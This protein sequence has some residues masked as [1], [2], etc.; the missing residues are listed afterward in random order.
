[1][2]IIYP[3]R[4]RYPQ[5]AANH[6]QATAMVCALGRLL[7]VHIYA[8]LH[9]GR[10]IAAY[11]EEEYQFPVPQGLHI[12]R[13]PF[14]NLSM[15]NFVLDSAAALALSGKGAVAYTRDVRRG[16]FC[17]QVQTL[18][19]RKF[20]IIH[21]VH[22]FRDEAVLA[23]VLQKAA[24]I[25]FIHERLEEETR[26]RLGYTGPGC[27]AQSGFDSG[28]FYPGKKESGNSIFTLVY[29][30]TVRE[31]KGVDLLLEMMP[32]LPEN[33]HLRMVGAPE[34][35]S[36]EKFNALMAAIPQRK[37]R[38]SMAGHK[39]HHAVAEELRNAGAM[40]LPPVPQ[41]KYYSQI[42]VFEALGCAVPIVACP[43]PH[44]T[45]FLEHGKTAFFTREPTAPAMAHAVG[46][47]MASVQLQENIRKGSLDMAGM[48]TW[49]A[50]AGRI[51]DFIAEVSSQQRSE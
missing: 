39:P 41:G 34:F 26:E 30:G 18:S 15:Y 21:E 23:R 7:P 33:V 46:E 2:H 40:V 48:Y 9:S 13:V 1:M 28:L 29:V 17:A 25:V 6:I 14:K 47:L 45:S 22:D 42:K 20:P 24:G 43:L 38:V 12:H 5:K 11:I 8:S 49:D 27:V 44:L 31:D 36:A 32:L 50:R 19:P 10:D 3:K 51:R 37:A 4:L 35:R 16:G